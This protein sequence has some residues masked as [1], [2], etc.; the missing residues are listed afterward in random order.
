MTATFYKDQTV[1]IT[2]V[3]VRYAGG[4]YHAREAL[5]NGYRCSCTSGGD[6]AAKALAAKMPSR[7][8]NYVMRLHA[9]PESSRRVGILGV[10]TE[11]HAPVEALKSQGITHIIIS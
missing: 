8:N 4:T 10:A 6:H 2:P 5:P 7:A 3:I 9:Y 11:E 1:T